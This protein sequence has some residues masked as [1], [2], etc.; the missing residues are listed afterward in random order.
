MSGSF[1]NTSLNHH[2]KWLEYSILQVVHSSLAWTRK[3]RNLSLA[4]WRNTFVRKILKVGKQLNAAEY[5]AQH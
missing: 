2:L 4:C 3:T 1:M 5:R